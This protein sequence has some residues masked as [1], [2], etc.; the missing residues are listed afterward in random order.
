MTSVLLNAEGLRKALA[1][2]DLCPQAFTGSKLES[3][4][5]PLWLTESRHTGTKGQ[6]QLC[7]CA[8]V[9]AG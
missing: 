2:I 7:Q 8:L 3:F 1:Q 4:A 9:C 5:L 6:G